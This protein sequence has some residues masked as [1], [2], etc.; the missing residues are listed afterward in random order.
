MS[1]PAPNIVTEAEQLRAEI[2][3][4][5]YRYYALDEPQVPDAEY[6]RL[7]LRLREIESQYPQLITPDSPTQ[8]V[9]AA[10]LSAFAT[11]Q[12]E[13]PMLSLDNA[14]SDEELINFNRRIQERL[15]HTDHIEFACEVKLDGIAVS[16]LYRDGILVRGA[17]RGDGAR[18]EDI[19][20]NVRTI[21][22]IPL[23]L[24]GTGFPSVLEVRGEIY[25]PKS[26]FEKMNN[27]AREKGEKLFVNPRNAAAG[28]LRQLD[29]RITASRPLEMCAYSVG[30]V[31][32]VPAEHPWPTRHSDIL[33]ALRDWGFLINREM[34][35]AKDIDECIAYYRKIQDKRMSLT[36]DIDGIVFKVNQRELQ[37]KLGFISRAPRWAIA[38]KFPAQEE[39]TQLLD[40]EFQVGRTGAVTPVA[41]LQPVFVGGVTVSNATLHNR[42]EIQRLGLKIG[43][44][45]IVRRAGDVIP[46]IVGIVD[47]KRPENAR[48]VVFPDHCPV[49]GSP[50]ETVPGE[51]VAR[52]DGGL[53]CPAQRKEAIKHFASRK[54][55]DVEGLGDKLVEQ[56]VDQG[57]IKAVADLY[58][59]TREQLAGLE[60]MGEKSADNLLNAL[61]KSKQTTLEKFIYALGI[62]E[63]GEATARNLALHFGNYAA[64][65]NATEDALQEVADVGPVVAHFVAEFFQQ[66][67]NR[68]AVTALKAAG[69]T[70]EDRDQ[71]VNT[72]DLPLKGLTYVLTGTLE[73]MS[74]DDAKAHLLALGAKV[75]GSVSAKT[76]Y[77]V[78]G[79]GAG[80]KLQK[81]E[82]LNIPV[83]DEA[84]LLALLQQ[85]QRAV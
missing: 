41:R 38:Y 30:L 83:L 77:V 65:S 27:Q 14:F 35:V 4:H 80:S 79:P 68:E 82:E 64:L 7:M 69:V 1:T 48:D 34:V 31:D 72:A 85:H 58:Q 51:A 49:C 42:D 63:V 62:R 43:D 17:T 74:R 75:A 18:G 40:V 19:T 55:M 47:T 22:S 44:T 15:K 23:R 16:L 9:G 39:M 84:G 61:E 5:N 3:D 50:V 56:L 36:Y 33:Y 53:I 60:R 73:A 66:E 8:R 24:R 52:C 67:H 71:P 6:D 59:L 2:H 13:M 81:A 12:H 11:V 25:M 46:Q 70:W 29:P 57:Y 54:A 28:S 10:P 45:V 20:Q 37:E 78:A 21:D 32:G 26:G 76:D